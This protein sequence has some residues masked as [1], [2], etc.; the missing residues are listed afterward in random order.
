MAGTEQQATMIRIEDF[1][2]FVES[3]LDALDLLKIRFARKGIEL[4]DLQA[5]QYFTWCHHTASTAMREMGGPGYNDLYLSLLGQVASGCSAY[6]HQKRS[7]VL[8]P[9]NGPRFNSP[10]DFAV[11]KAVH[12]VPNETTGPT[13]FKYG[14]YL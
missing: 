12:H 14:G 1:D 5:W 13:E 6:F 8:A 11:A 7:G 3:Q 2:Q 9:P 10:L 4:T